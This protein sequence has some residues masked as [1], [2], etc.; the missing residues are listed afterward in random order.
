MRTRSSRSFGRIAWTLV[1]VAAY[2]TG[3]GPTGSTGNA[4]WKFTNPLLEVEAGEWAEYRTSDQ[5]TMRLDVVDVGPKAGP[6]TIRERTF[7]GDV[8]APIADPSRKPYDRNHLMNGYR[9]AGWIVGRIFEDVVTVADRRWKS[10]C[11]EYSTMRHGLVRV[12]YS[13][14][15]P[16]YGMLRQVTV[17]P[18]GQET[19]RTELVDWSGKQE[20]K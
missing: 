20:A 15:V 19:V 7:T 17:S 6:V 10:V 18:K 2:T 16:V 9:S 11:F 8:D 13:H 5:N 14:E 12:W 4:N 3:C 1:L